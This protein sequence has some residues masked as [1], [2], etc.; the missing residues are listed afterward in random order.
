MALAV[1]GFQ[2]APKWR[3][4]LIGPAR[5]KRQPESK[6]QQEAIVPHPLQVAPATAENMTI[7][8]ADDESSFR[9][10]LALKLRDSVADV[11]VLEAV[12]GAEAVRLGLQQHPLIA[13]LDV[14]MPRLG[15]V[16]TALTLRSLR[17]T[18]EIALQSGDAEEYRVGATGLGLPLFDKRDLEQPLAWVKARAR[19]LI[20]REDGSPPTAE[21]LA[22]D[23]LA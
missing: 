19:K 23:R 10:F 1:N 8:I 16:E 13:L 21:R 12:D 11:D 4:D 20:T 5:S 9:S 7:L 17:P 15:G 6:P 22:F 3:S 14:S 2:A 18:M